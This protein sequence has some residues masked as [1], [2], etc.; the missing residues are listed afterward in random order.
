MWY[1]VR[2]LKLMYSTNHFYTRSGV[3]NEHTHFDLHEATLSGEFLR[4]FRA[5]YNGEYSPRKYVIL[6]VQNAEKCMVI[7]TNSS[8][9][10][11]M[12]GSIY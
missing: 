2:K 1:S 7:K 11:K 12:A 10:M 8:L 9:C 3:F 5:H 4:W 6:F